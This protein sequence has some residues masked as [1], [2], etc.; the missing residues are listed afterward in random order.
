M[1]VMAMQLYPEA[2]RKA[3]KEIDEVIG[4][5]RLPDFS[6]R[7]SLPMVECV[8]QEVLRLYNPIPLGKY[9]SCVIIL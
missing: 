4:P 6:D 5:N 7:E 2:Q 3:Q 1:F 8:I 9:R